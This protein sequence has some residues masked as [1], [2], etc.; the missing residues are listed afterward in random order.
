MHNRILTAG[1]VS[2]VALTWSSMPA[3]A[4]DGAAVTGGGSIAGVVKF[5]GT[6]PAP[7]ELEVTKDKQVCGAHKIVDES[8]VVAADGGIANAVVSITNITK[9]KPMAAAS[10]V[11]DQHGCTYVPHVQAFPAGSEVQIKNSDGILHNIHTY[12]EKNPSINRAQPKFKKVLNETF[13]VP[14]TIKV[15]CDAHNWMLGYFIVQ[16]HPY[17][18]VTDA[19]GAYKLTD[20]PAGDYELKVWHEK[21]G[22]ST[23]K[24]TVAAGGA[25]SANFELA[26]K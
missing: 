22:E 26:A 24:V 18:A 6:A 23:Q 11:L 10:P 19:T 5:K 9:G 13:K 3:T 1:V 16:D 2:L 17:Y 14:E 20:V 15:T 7:K 12:S 25:A 21:L 8:L 4:Y